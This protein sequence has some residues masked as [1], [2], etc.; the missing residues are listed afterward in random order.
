V[1]S[2]FRSSETPTIVVPVDGR[3]TVHEAVA[4]G[5]DFAS[6]RL[7]EQTYRSIVS[8]VAREVAV[9]EQ[10]LHA[11]IAVESAYLADAVSPKGAQGLMQ[12]MPETARRFGVSDPFDPRDNVRGG[13]LYL[14]WLL[15]LFGGDLALALAAFNAGEQAVIRAGYRI[16][17]YAETQ[18]YVPR[19]MAR[20]ERAVRGREKSS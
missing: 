13:A 14:K 15:N 5:S 4:R 10:M 12:L 18:R 6:I 2:N 7:R 9:S 8:E 3:S 11:V 16:P 20:L 17:P 1:L 19:V